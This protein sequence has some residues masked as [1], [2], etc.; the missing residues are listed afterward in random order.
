MLAMVNELKADD[1]RE[2]LSNCCRLQVDRSA[3]Q[4]TSLLDTTTCRPADLGVVDS[5]SALINF[6][7]GGAIVFFLLARQWGRR[8][9]AEIPG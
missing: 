6:S 7:A 2:A 3:G 8:R 5:Q 1:I 4:K 9:I